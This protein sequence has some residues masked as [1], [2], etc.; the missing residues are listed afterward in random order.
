[1]C[2]M[3][4]ARAPVKTVSVPTV[5]LLAAQV[6]PAMDLQ[7]TPEER[8]LLRELIQE[9]HR[10]LILEIARTDHHH[11]RQV[12][13]TKQKVMEQLLEKVAGELVTD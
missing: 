1:M 9:R 4:L 13:R 2:I 3:V 10:D 5:A 6:R 11:F 12:L 8:E 7:L